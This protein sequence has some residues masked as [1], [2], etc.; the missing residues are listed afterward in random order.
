MRKSTRD[1]V[2]ER[3]QEREQTQKLKFRLDPM[4]LQWRQFQ[5]FEK[6][7]ISQ[8]KS[9]QIA[10]A[11]PGLFWGMDNGTITHSDLN[12]QLSWQAY[13]EHVARLV[14]IKSKNILFSLGVLRLLLIDLR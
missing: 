10:C 9:D 1:R 3:V 4:T 7:L 6:Q 2:Q 8:E 14:F 5:F 11:A 12:Q 13:Q